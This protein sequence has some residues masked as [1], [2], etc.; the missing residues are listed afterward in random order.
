MSEEQHTPLFSVLDS[1]FLYKEI[2]AN[3]FQ[4]LL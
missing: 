1:K 2:I 3:Q 4:G